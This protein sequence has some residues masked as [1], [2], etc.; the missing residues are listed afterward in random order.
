M[1][2][3]RIVVADDEIDIRRL[4]AY[5]LRRQGYVVWEASEGE[6]ALALARQEHP[7][8]VLLDVLMPG[9]SGLEVATALATDPG[10]AAIPVIMLSALGQ[11][12]DVAAGRETGARAYLTKPF[13]PSELA[14]RVATVLASQN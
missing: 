3:Q 8:L 4:V 2:G 14:E 6:E 5:T 7:D 9:L 1:T 12:S 11:S 10:T 13:S